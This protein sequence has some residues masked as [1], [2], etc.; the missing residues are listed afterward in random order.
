MPIYQIISSYTDF[1]SGLS[2]KLRNF[3]EEATPQDAL[4]IAKTWNDAYMQACASTVSPVDARI[5]NI[6]VTLDMF[7]VAKASLGAQQGNI[8]GLP[9]EIS[10]YAKWTGFG[11]V[12]TRGQS[13]WKLHGLAET[14]VNGS[15]LDLANPIVV[16]LS[17]DAFAYFQQYRKVATGAPNNLPVVSPPIDFVNYNIVGMYSRKLGRSFLSPGQQRRYTRA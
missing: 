1:D 16:Q 13:G 11:G 17:N 6:A 12:G 8:G 5:S 4:L 7:V 14:L 2:W 15:K 9:T 10:S 3:S